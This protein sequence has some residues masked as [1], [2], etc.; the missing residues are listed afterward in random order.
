MGCQVL[1]GKNALWSSEF[2]HCCITQA[3]WAS[4]VVLVVKNT[5]AMQGMRVPSLGLEEPL[6]KGVAIHSSIL[7]WRIPRTEE[8]GGLQSMG[9]QRVRHDWSDLA[10]TSASFLHFEKK[11]ILSRRLI[12]LNIVWVDADLGYAPQ[13][14]CSRDFPGSPVVMISLPK[15]GVQ[16]QSL[17]V[18]LRPPQAKGPKN[19]K[20]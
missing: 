7:A 19:P 10:C 4:Q 20:T 14:R 6:E 17:V 13:E 5:A 2:L 1:Q 9:S 16:L 3:L 15:Q 12:S 11:K 8:S 18:E